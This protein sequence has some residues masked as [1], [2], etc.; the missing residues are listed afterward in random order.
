MQN[1]RRMLGGKKFDFPKD[2]GV[3]KKFIGVMTADNDLVLDTF[4]GSGTTGQAVLELNQ[5]DRGN[6]RFILVE[7]EKDLCREVA[8]TRLSQTINGYQTDK[9]KKIT[10]TGGGFRYCELGKALFDENG[11]IAAE[12][13]FPDLAAHIFFSETGIPIPRRATGKSPLLGEHGGKAVYLLFK[14]RHG[15]QTQDERKHPD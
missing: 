5:E 2:V 3:L 7:M 14:R 10:G 13:K 15:R 9:G 8:V 11:G 1:L 6:R 12:V 4:A